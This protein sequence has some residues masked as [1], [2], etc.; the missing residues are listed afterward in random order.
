MALDEMAA[1]TCATTY[2]CPV[3]IASCPE[4]EEEVTINVLTLTEESLKKKYP[5]IRTIRITMMRYVLFFDDAL[6][7]SLSILRVDKSAVEA[8]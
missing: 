6:F 4:S 5:P 3:K 7:P 2:P 1:F 8:L